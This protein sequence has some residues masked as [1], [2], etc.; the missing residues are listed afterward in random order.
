ML[1]VGLLLLSGLSAPAL[2]QQENESGGNESVLSDDA[3]NETDPAGEAG[4]G[5]GDGDGESGP[6]L[7][8]NF[9]NETNVS[10][11]NETNATG[12]ES[13]GSGGDGGVLPSVGMP[14]VP[15]A[16]ELLA[17]AT[18]WTREDLTEGIN[19]YVTELNAAFVGLATPG[20]PTDPGS[21]VMPDNDLWP[22][23]VSFYWGSASLASVLIA[24]GAVFIFDVESRQKQREMI[25]TVIYALM[26]ILLG[27]V[28]LGLYFNLINEVSMAVAPDGYEFM[29]SEENQEKL[30]AGHIIAF[31]LVTINAGVVFVGGLIL[32]GIYLWPYI[33]YGFWPLLMGAKCVPIDELQSTA[34]IGLTSLV[35]IPLLRLIQSLLLRLAFEIPWG[36]SSL[37]VEI[38]ALLSVLVILVIALLLLPWMFY[39][40]IS[41]ASAL[42]LGTMAVSGT[43]RASSKAVDKGGSAVSRATAR[44]RKAVGAYA[45]RARASASRTAANAKRQAKSRAGGA[46]LTAKYGRPGHTTPA[47]AAKSNRSSMPDAA[48]NRA[49]RR[50]Q[51]DAAKRANKSRRTTNDD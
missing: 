41:T 23:I 22:G 50:E 48:R 45:D 6:V 28:I 30:L 51:R 9:G 47:Q 2:A 40:K 46:I 7:P 11:G 44:P 15:S 42:M 27:T 29:A 13:G 49:K 24:L 12:N 39:R 43:N 17:D 19:A 36:N 8:D 16:G 33:I 1:V 35:L 34:N 31:A 26:G 14:S 37:G 25:R 38:A 32:Y 21:W 10:S 20:T 5:D 4:D 18:D 3:S